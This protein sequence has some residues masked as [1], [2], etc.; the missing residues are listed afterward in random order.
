MSKRSSSFYSQDPLHG[1]KQFY[2]GDD[3]VELPVHDGEL[4][5]PLSGST[6]VC[7]P[8]LL[9][10]CLLYNY[11]SQLKNFTLKSALHFERHIRNDIYFQ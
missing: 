1:K 9:T 4:F 6:K 2:D 3:D 7:T 5:S 10:I 8:I 11:P